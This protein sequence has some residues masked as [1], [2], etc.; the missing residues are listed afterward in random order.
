MYDEDQELKLA[1]ICKVHMLY[2]EHVGS[3]HALHETAFLQLADA[4]VVRF[5]CSV[6]AGDCNVVH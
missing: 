4:V 1:G 2:T 5:Y 3:D 6:D